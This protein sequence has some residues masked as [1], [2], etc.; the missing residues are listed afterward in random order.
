MAAG[1]ARITATKICGCS[2]QIRLLGCSREREDCRRLQGVY[3]EQPLYHRC[4]TS[5]SVRVLL[6]RI[7]TGHEVEHNTRKKEA[8]Y[9]HED[10][11]QKSS[12]AL[13][14]KYITRTYSACRP[15]VSVVTYP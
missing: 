13:G 12:R 2:T 9:F 4:V 8:I 6:N 1:T 11:D 10:G 14:R 7:I 15:S 5:L 3:R